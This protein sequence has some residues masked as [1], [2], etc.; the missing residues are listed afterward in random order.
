VAYFG[1]HS[2]ASLWAS[3][4]C[5]GVIFAAIISR[6]SA[7]VLSPPRRSQVVPHV[8][9]YIV[10][11]DAFAPFV[12]VTQIK[13]GIPLGKPILIGRL[14][15]PNYR[16]LVVLR[17]PLA[18]SCRRVARTRLSVLK[19]RQG[20]RPTEPRPKLANGANSLPYPSGLPSSSF[21]RRS[22]NASTSACI[23]RSA[24]AQAILNR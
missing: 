18:V 23:A 20:I 1:F 17:N 14:S 22:M 5:A 11:W 16:S 15:I 10:L 21:V 3:A 6:G 8:R 4:I 19:G 12:Y 13:L 9:G 7:A 24:L 2:R